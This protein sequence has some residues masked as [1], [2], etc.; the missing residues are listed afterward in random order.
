[1]KMTFGGVILGMAWTMD[2]T[3]ILGGPFLNNSMNF[4]TKYL[5]LLY[6]YLSHQWKT[7]IIVIMR[8]I[9]KTV[10]CSPTQTIQNNAFMAR[11]TIIVLTV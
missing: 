8:D 6:I 2:K 4:A 5:S 9:S 7:R 11:Q 3:L 1:M 10:I